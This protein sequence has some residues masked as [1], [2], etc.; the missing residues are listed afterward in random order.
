M[1]PIDRKEIQAVLTARYEELSLAYGRRD[2][3]AVEPTADALDATRSAESRE[4]AARSLERETILLREVRLGL[5]RIAE[6][7]YGT[8]LECGNEITHKR[9]RA[10]PW[11]TLCL[12]CQ[13]QKDTSMK[14]ARM[15]A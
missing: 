13:E 11:T 1:I 6:G 8:C 9:L 10:L 3:L 4:L 14:P 5:A 12:D 2:G 15:A 7:T